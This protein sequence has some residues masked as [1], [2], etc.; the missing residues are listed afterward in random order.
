MHPHLA[1]SSAFLARRFVAVV[2]PLALAAAPLRG[3][4]PAP[5]APEPD[6]VDADLQAFRS[7][8]QFTLFGTADRAVTGMRPKGQMEYYVT[9]TG[10][11]D[12]AF[13][14]MDT[15][16]DLH[17]CVKCPVRKW[18]D[19]SPMYAASKRDWERFRE[20][21][22]SLGRA[23]GGGWSASRNFPTLGLRDF[24]ASDGQLG[25]LFSGATS[26]QGDRAC[27]DFSGAGPAEN[28]MARGLTL[29]AGSDCLPTWPLVDGFPTFRGSPPMS[30]NAFRATQAAQGQAFGF[31]WWGVDPT[32]VDSTLFFGH[33]QTY[34]AFDDYNSGLIGRFGDVVPGGTG[35][36]TVEGRPL[37]IRTEFD[38]FVFPIPGVSNSLFWRT[39]II[40]NETEK[41]Y[42]V[43]LDYENLYVGYT[44]PPTS[45][46]DEH[47]FYAEVWRG[48]LI[49]VHS[50]TGSPPCPGTPPP[51]GG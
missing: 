11:V 47:A 29:L 42:G 43:P 12:G 18:F 37:G 40:K 14:P 17:G 28:N 34:G 30:Q 33:S 26:T 22:P 45:A 5:A 3:Q 16:P 51:N 24:E 23:L 48:T 19:I 1:R 49:A 35:A 31:D 13:L 10:I 32:L 25:V 2:L 27:T 6:L 20:D 44:M 38:A 46:G 4:H 36:P 15:G 7:Q 21:V 50:G 9:N 8:S 41:V 39:L